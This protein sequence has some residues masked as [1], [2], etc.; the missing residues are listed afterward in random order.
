[1]FDLVLGCDT[2]TRSWVLGL[3]RCID[4]GLLEGELVMNWSRFWWR[5]CTGKVGRRS[6]PYRR[7]GRL[8][9]AR[10]YRSTKRKDAWVGA[11]FLLTL[12]VVILACAG[13]W[14]G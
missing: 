7:N 10:E 11:V 13:V 14:G 9:V 4:G 8:D 6:R 3:V 12:G 5:V 1:M 2:G